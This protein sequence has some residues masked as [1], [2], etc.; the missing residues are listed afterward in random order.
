MKQA[1]QAVPG[2]VMQNLKLMSGVETVFVLRAEDAPHLEI[3]VQTTTKLPDENRVIG[4]IVSGKVNLAQLSMHQDPTNSLN[5]YLQQLYAEYR[6][7][8]ADGKNPLWKPE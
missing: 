4:K 5:N 3:I 8:N 1:F 2:I 7:S 6:K